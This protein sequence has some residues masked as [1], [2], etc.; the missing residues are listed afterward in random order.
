MCAAD[1]GIHVPQQH[2]AALFCPLWMCHA[3]QREASCDRMVY[4]KS[5]LVIDSDTRDKLRLMLGPRFT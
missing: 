3:E 2:G 4:P 1:P 5:S